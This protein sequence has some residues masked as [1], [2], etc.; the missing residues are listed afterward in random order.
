MADISKVKLPDNSSY[1]I[2]ASKIPYG[3]LDST[4]T[5][6]VMTA[7]VPGITAL[8]DGTTIMLENGVVTSASGFT[9]DINGLGAKPVYSNLAA[10]TRDTTIFNVNYTMLFVYDSNRVSGGAW[11]CYRGYDANTNTIGYQV[12]YNSASKPASDKGYKY[13]LWLTSVDG[14]EWVPINTST[15]TNATTARTLNTRPIDPFGPIVYHSANDTTN[16]GT[17]LPVATNW[18]QD[19]F[20]IGYS[21]VIT[22][23]A[24]Q[25][26]YLQCTPQ[27]T[28]GAVMNTITQTL[29]TTED[30]KIYIFLGVAYGTSSME[31]WLEHPVYYFKD[32]A[33]RLWTNALESGVSVDNT[34]VDNIVTSSAHPYSASNPM[35]TV[36]DISAAGGGTVTSVNIGTDT[37]TVITTSGGPVTASGT[38]KV[39]HAKPTV[40][41]AKSVQAIYPIK[42]DQYGHITSAGSTPIY[43]DDYSAFCFIVTSANGAIID[44]AITFN[45]IMAAVSENKFV[46]LR[47]ADS[48]M[49]PLSYIDESSFTIIFTTVDPTGDENSGGVI[50]YVCTSSDAYSVLEIIEYHYDISQIAV[51]DGSLKLKKNSGTATTKFTANQSSTSTLTFTTTSVGSAS[52]WNAGSATTLG[53]AIPADD[54]TAWT[55]NKPTVID[56]TKF[57][58]GSFTQGTDLFKEATLN[59]SLGSDTATAS[60]PTTL[61]FSFSGGS[62][63]QGSDSHT[64]A[65]LASGFYTAGSAASLSYTAKSIPNVTS[66]GTA[67]SLTITSTEVVNDLS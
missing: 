34:K 20:T 60:N 25:P 8:E 46:Y 3:K 7:T 51:N 65:S 29:P 63:T 21:Y 66:A 11:I 47:I 13:R 61:T 5:S 24:N 50:Q 18:Q 4:S 48:I 49:A 10:A 14:T 31:L 52:G 64:A 32:G 36:G 12:R 53:T 43:A 15:A 1:I 54:I 42:I 39:N 41:P 57:N 26:V 59:A 62:F 27:S 55:T 56:T 2:K 44:N 16:A 19:S 6:T 38:L 22:L 58:G 67:P 33:I 45:D 23:T 40:S 30:G 37:S 9:I 35:A 28:G 17:N